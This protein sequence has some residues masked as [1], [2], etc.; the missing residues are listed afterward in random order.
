MQAFRTRWRNPHVQTVIGRM[1]RPARLPRADLQWV[2]VSDADQLAVFRHPGSPDLPTVLIVHGLGGSAQSDYVLAT[3]RGLIAHGFPVARVDLRGAGL[4]GTRCTGMYHG[5]RTEDL[6]AVVDALDGPVAVIGFSLGGNAT[7]KLLGEQPEGIVAGIAVSTPLDLA[8]GAEHLHH[9]AG[10]MY[11]KFLMRK[12]R[13]E[14]LR[15]GARFTPEDRAAILGARRIVEF[16]NAITAP[17]HGW[18]D[19]AEYYEV[20]SSIRFLARVQVP[21]LVLHSRDDPMVP[22][23]PYESVDW[24]ALPTTSLVLTEHGGHVGFHGRSGQPYY[25]ELATAFFSAGGS[26]AAAVEVEPQVRDQ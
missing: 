4:S 25:V 18:R 2:P 8:V 13:A 11:E 15:P 21:L 1:Q 24:A 3:A 20:N 10:G 12:L 9:M 26:G 5:G 19:A 7:I 23:G 22:L 16:D 6:R 17:R 14:S